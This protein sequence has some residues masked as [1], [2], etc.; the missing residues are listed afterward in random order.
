MTTTVPPAEATGVQAS[1]DQAVRCRAS[2][3][4]W[5]AA[6]APILLW[7]IHLTFEASF[8]RHVDVH[9]STEWLLHLGTVVTA[10]PTALCL[11]WSW[12]VVQRAGDRTHG[13]DEAGVEAEVEALED[14]DGGDCSQLRFVGWLGVGIGAFNL[15][16]IL[17]EGSYVLFLGPRAF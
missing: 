4:D 3:V 10:V 6:T 13:R 15:L 1:D 2:L 9:P 5:I 12:R 14:D 17:W 7:M 11:L 8:A 16:L